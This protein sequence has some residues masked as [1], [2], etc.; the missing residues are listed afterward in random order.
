MDD[1][2]HVELM[3]FKCVFYHHLDCPVKK[4]YILRP[5]NLTKF[6]EVCKIVDKKDRDKDVRGKDTNS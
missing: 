1:S 6:C 4:M 3:K 2:N 5:E